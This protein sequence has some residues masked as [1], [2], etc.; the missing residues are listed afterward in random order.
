MKTV[1]RKGGVFYLLLEREN[2]P[3]EVMDIL[4]RKGLEGSVMD[5]FA[6]NE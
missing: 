6:P 2:D 5:V 3:E 4:A 1:L